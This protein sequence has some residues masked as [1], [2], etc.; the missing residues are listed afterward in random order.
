MN[1]PSLFKATFEFIQD[2]NTNGTTEDIESLII[3]CENIDADGCFYVLKT[4]GW[5]IDEPEEIKSLIERINKII[6]E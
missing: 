4:N 2:G 6:I 1:K 3:E 5:S